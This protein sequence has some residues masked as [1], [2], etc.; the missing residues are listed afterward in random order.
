[1][2]GI[3]WDSDQADATE[4][5]FVFD[6]EN[7]VRDLNDVIILSGWILTFARDINDEGEV[8]GYGEIN[9]KK[10][11]YVLA[12]S[13]Q[14]SIPIG[15]PGEYGMISGDASQVNEVMFSFGGMSGDIVLKYEVYDAD[16][17][18]EIQILLNGYEVGYAPLSGNN[19]WG[20]EQRIILPDEY[21]N[22]SGI[23]ILTFNSTC[24]PPNAWMWGVRNVSV[25]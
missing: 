12:P 15:T 25:E 10:R 5:A 20:G 14:E 17:D 21:V 9:G 7:G 23:N 11:G 8:V 6:A 2:V 1:M 16:N 4:H 13:A 18:T 19:S 24:N 22:D 3:M